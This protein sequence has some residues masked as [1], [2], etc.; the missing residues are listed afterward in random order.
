MIGND[1]PSGLFNLELPFQQ[2]Q[3]MKKAILI[4]TC[5]AALSAFTAIGA[6]AQTTGPSGQ[7]TTTKGTDTMSK[8]GMSKGSIE[9]KG[10]SK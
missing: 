7:D 1:E 6:S 9:T 2:E 3:I 10:M 5:V 4:T 8:D